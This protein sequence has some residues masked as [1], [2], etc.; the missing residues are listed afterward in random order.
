[1]KRKITQYSKLVW[2]GMLVIAGLVSTPAL[3]TT[4]NLQNAIN[5]F[6]PA[7]GINVPA[8]LNSDVNP[9]GPETMQG[10]TTYRA[11]LFFEGGGFFNRNKLYFNDGTTDHLV[12]DGPDNAVTVKT[13]TTTAPS[14]SF[15]LVSP[16]DS[17]IFIGGTFSSITSNNSD[18]A[19]HF[20]ILGYPTQ[21][22]KF[23]IGAE[24]VKNG[25]D[26][27]Y[28]D[29]TL[30]LE[31]LDYDR[32]GVLVDKDN[33]PKDSNTDQLDT[34]KDGIGNACDPDDDD[35]GV[36]DISDNCKL[37][38]NPDQHDYD[39]DGIGDACDTDIDGDLVDDGTDTCPATPVGSIVNATGC[40]IDQICSCDTAWKNHGAYVS[41]TART[42][43]D[44]MNA[45]L[46]TGDEF[47]A[48]TS[49]AAQSTCGNNK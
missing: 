5:S 42:A 29:M 47:G 43:N 14:I 48:I 39:K 26:R 20:I 18:N 45:G 2:V 7:R 23:L 15:K 31:D 28:E 38:S 49:S 4:T 36:P 17:P 46:I 21:P 8:L 13:F 9:A 16:T 24:D 3:S 34:D 37:F 22:E 6:P 12:F 44:F 33:C 11:T 10:D 35:D 19:D 32:D 27:D 1:M 40:S 25:G 30:L 41:C